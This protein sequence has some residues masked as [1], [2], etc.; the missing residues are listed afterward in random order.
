MQASDTNHIQVK[1]SPVQERLEYIQLI[2]V[3]NVQLLRVRRDVD[4]CNSSA[5]LLDSKERERIDK[6]Q[7]GE[8]RVH[9]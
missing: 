3:L 2:S 5:S 4:H 9:N 7:M 1:G 6:T 8:N